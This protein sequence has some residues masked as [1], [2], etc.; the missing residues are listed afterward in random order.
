MK[1]LPIGT[2][3]N[4]KYS[5]KSTNRTTYR[6]E[7]K[8]DYVLPVYDPYGYSLILKNNV[9][10]PSTRLVCSN[11]TAFFRSDLPWDSLTMFLSSQMPYGKV[12]V[13]NFACSD[14]SEA[15]SL[16]LSLIEK[17]G[18]DEA[19]KFFPI[20]ASDVD[21]EIVKEANKGE[22]KAT[23]QEV[24]RISEMISHPRKI[25][26]YFDVMKLDDDKDFDFVLH[27]KE[28][29]SQHVFFVHQDIEDGLDFVS[30]SNSLILARNFWRYLP[31]DKLASTSL[32]LRKNL[33]SSSRIM[34][35]D[36]DRMDKKLP[37]FLNNLGIKS[38]RAPHN[39][40]RDA[41]NQY[42]NILKID[43]SFQVADD[44]STL[45]KIRSGYD[46]FKMD[47]GIF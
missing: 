30:K 14:G 17:L 35:G 15:Y 34:I 21:E 1:I 19:Q 37:Y 42:G 44:E 33:D 3:N 39:L 20:I 38:V 6:D 9:D 12:N 11:R 46:S 43:D 10:N 29:L 22:L 45:H 5:F 16:V 31:A 8:G 47:Y 23:I 18:E 28:K 41:L 26:D 36:F 32:K 13:Y 2:N 27:P 40:N 25:T 7:K 4:Y 24:K